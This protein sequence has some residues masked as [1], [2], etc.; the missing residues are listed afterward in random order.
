MTVSWIER[1][2]LFKS[3]ARV[4]AGFLLRSRETQ[5]A[6]KR[7]WQ[8]E[9]RKRNAQLNRQS[10]VIEEQRAEIAR[11]K[12]QVQQLQ[13]Q[14]ALAAKAAPA[15]PVDPPLKGHQFGP[16]QVGLAVNLAQAA[17]FRAAC[18]SA[19]RKIGGAHSNAAAK[20]ILIRRMN[21]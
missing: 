5:A 2:K 8:Q 14:V 1:T 13:G 18:G 3:P 17:G 4:A 9:C 10:A 7:Y 21:V 11:L 15:L 20:T 6:S 12:R 16:R 19:L